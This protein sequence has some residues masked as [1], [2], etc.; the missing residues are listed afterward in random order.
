[1]I[2]TRDATPSSRRIAS[3][4]ASPSNAGISR[5]RRI[6]SHARGRAASTASFPSTTASTTIP[7]RLSILV[8]TRRFTVL[9]SA[10]GTRAPESERTSDDAG[11]FAGA[12][13][14]RLG[15]ALEGAPPAPPAG[16]R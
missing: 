15:G 3:A 2:G 9:S 13:I 6:A 10:S 16:S 5:S 11:A 14:D 7:S 4:A 12:P 1:M 8:E